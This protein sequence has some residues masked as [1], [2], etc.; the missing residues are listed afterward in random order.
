MTNRFPR[1]SALFIALALSI[2]AG[3]VDAQPSIASITPGAVAP[4]ATTE[5][6]LT[7]DNLNDLSVWTS[8]PATVE[9]VPN[10]DP[11]VKNVAKLKV[12]LDASVPVQIGGLLISNPGGTPGARLFMVD[13]LST[14]ADNGANA[15]VEAAQEIP[16]PS[17][18]DVTSNGSALDHY[19]FQGTKGQNVSIEAISNRLASPMDPV[20]RLFDAG[21]NEVAAADDDEALGADCRFRVALPAD[22]TYFIE[23]SDNKFGGGTCRLRVG[24]FPLVNTTFPLAVNRNESSDLSFVGPS[25][26]GAVAKSVAVPAAPSV[27]A[28]AASSGF[29]G[30]VGSG[31]A[32]VLAGTGPQ[33]I[34]QEPNNDIAQS[35]SAVV[36][37][38]LNGILNEPG[39]KD[40]FKFSATKD[41]ILKFTCRSRSVGSPAVVSMS[42]LKADGSAVASAAVNDKDEFFIKA[43]IPEDGEYVITVE[44]LV[45]RGGPGFSYVVQVSQGH[46]FN[47]TL[48]NDKATTNTYMVDAGKGAIQFPVVIGRDGYNGPITLGLDPPIEGAKFWDPVLGEGA[49]EA[50][51][52]LILPPDWGNNGARTINVVG[53][54]TIG[55]A[56]VVVPME[57]SVW[58]KTKHAMPYI[59]EWY[60]SPIFLASTTAIEEYFEPALPTPELYFPKGQTSITWNVGIN[61]KNGD[62]KG[63]MTLRATGWPEGFAGALKVD[64]DS[65]TYTVT[66]P[67]DAAEGEHKLLLEAY[68]THA[69]HGHYITREVALKVVNPMTIEVKPPAALTIGTT[70]TIDVTTNRG[71]GNTGVVNVNVKNL[72]AGVTVGD[73]VGIL[74]DGKTIRLNLVV[75]ADAAA[76]VVE[77]IVVEATTNF[78]GAT[79]T[80][81]SDPIKLEVKKAE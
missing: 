26:I 29:D 5:L 14:V 10:E 59:P 60:A 61:R 30:V 74:A 46:S 33:S 4:G 50:S 55:E 35:S 81:A 45:Q 18:V 16:F 24:D 78:S 12:T 48:K 38:G 57:G 54:A 67:A 17:A 75:A 43:T 44:D 69:G 22:G 63:A 40:H 56:E 21:G 51:V 41:Q 20:V 15:S 79:V 27:S 3:N 62:F 71:A 72:P 68:S 32:T 73:G 36:P 8:F 70:Q 76:A 53:K 9:I 6:T 37:G 11:A 2:P 25:A 23:V 31:I 49:K 65:Y 1:L 52:I 80:V 66:A 42:L 34:E 64:K 77:N 58:L 47:L 7:G 28:V 39:D 13:D 19:K